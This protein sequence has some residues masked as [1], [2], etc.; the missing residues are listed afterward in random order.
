[1]PL[2]KV[3]TL[4]Q[5]AQICETSL[6][7]GFDKNNCMKKYGISRSCLNRILQNKEKF[8]SFSDL[9][10]SPAKFK[11]L[12]TVRSFV[13]TNG[14]S[15][16]IYRALAELETMGITKKLSDSSNQT[17]INMFFQ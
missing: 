10:G 5:K 15:E 17:T 7:P 2:N 16:N 14:A 11:N 3:L 9:K 6:A 12:N 8:M 1:M 4:H 13:Q